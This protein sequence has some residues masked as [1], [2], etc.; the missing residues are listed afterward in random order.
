MWK[1]YPYYSAH[2]ITTKCSKLHLRCSKLF[3]L[4]VCNVDQPGEKSE[5]SSFLEVV[6]TIKSACMFIIYTLYYNLLRFI[7]WEFDIHCSFVKL[8]HLVAFLALINSMGDKCTMMWL[9]SK[10]FYWKNTITKRMF[11]FWNCNTHYFGFI[12]NELSFY[13]AIISNLL[14]FVIRFVVWFTIH[15]VIIISRTKHPYLV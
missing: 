12:L 5:Q 4:E 6:L 15:I 8:L 2:Q 7:S 10:V 3:L 9:V 1:Y 14:S 13:D 11:F